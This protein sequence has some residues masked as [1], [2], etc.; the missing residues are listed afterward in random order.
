MGPQHHVNLALGHH[1][2]TSAFVGHPK[3]QPSHVLP[4][5][6]SGGRPCPLSQSS[7]L[8]LL[9]APYP[10]SDSQWT[11]ERRHIDN[12][13]GWRRRQPLAP[14]SLSST[15]NPREGRIFFHSK[16]SEITLADK[17]D[18][19]DT[20]RSNTDTDDCDSTSDTSS[21]GECKSLSASTSHYDTTTPPSLEIYGIP[22][23][24]IL[25][26]NLVAVIW[27][28]QHAVIKT[29]V[30]G[31]IGIDGGGDGTAAYFTLA[32]FGLAA[33]LAAPYT[34]GWSQPEQQIQRL[35]E[36]EK[37]ASGRD[38][39]KYEL[40][41]EDNSND[42]DGSILLTTSTSAGRLA[43][44]Y[45]AELGLYMFLGYAFQAI[46]LETTTASRSGFLLYLN[47]K[48]V[49]FLSYLI[50]G[51]RIRRGTWISA[52]VAFCGTALLALDVG[53]EYAATAATSTITAALSVGDLWS[54]AAAASSA[55]FILRMES[56]S[57]AIPKSSELNATTLWTVAA[58]SF[59]WAMVISLNESISGGGGGGTGINTD[60]FAHAI[61]LLYERT[62]S[63][64]TTHLFPL[65]Y[66]SGI[67]TA[68]ANF[69]QSKAQKNISAERASV[70][71][72]MDPV[73][74]AIFANVLLGETLGGLG[75]VGAFLIV[76]AAATNASM[77]FGGKSGGGQDE[78]S[79][80]GMK[81]TG[82]SMQ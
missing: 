74:G 29:V 34:P 41:D 21:D 39:K 56:A 63:T 12:G 78:D 53:G 23:Q 67:T 68:L 76:V 57:M 61:L 3:I 38:A 59:L 75:L 25:L 45:G 28:T 50:F 31:G 40:A 16:S 77:D 24:S 15:S 51:R 27:G 54:I 73:Y 49:P 47:V 8:R 80:A 32:R 69:L 46:G 72:A 60:A 58:L 4:R 44:K 81:G 43:W 65:I 17:I 5:V 62:Y 30:D 64:I 52:L 9:G 20:A 79:D 22:I 26:L 10:R 7:S 13:E 48:F 6:V 2:M 35:V 14:S 18:K 36:I 70:I 66:L 33:A 1:E 82:R 55:L 42:E 11:F 37:Y 71:Y 19:D